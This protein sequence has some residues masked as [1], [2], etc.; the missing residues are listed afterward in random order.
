MCWCV[1]II[2]SKVASTPDEVALYA[3]CTLLAAT[4]AASHEGSSNKLNAVTAC[5]DYLR[6]NE[7]IAQR[8]ITD[9]GILPILFMFPCH[10]WSDLLL[11]PWKAAPTFESNFELYS[12][13]IVTVQFENSYAVDLII[14][15]SM[16]VHPSVNQKRFL[17]LNEILYLR[18]GRW[19]MHNSLPCDPIQGQGHRDLTVVKMAD[20]KVCLLRRYLRKQKT[21]DELWYSKKISKF[22]TGHFDIHLCS[23]PC[24]LIT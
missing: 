12:I 5:V 21:N 16:S 13:W 8:T 20:F 18:R 11:E 6:E 2:V 4:L 15:V 19:M 1:Q 17:D 24:D 10:K 7:F 9:S 23:V 3:E 22:L 14:S